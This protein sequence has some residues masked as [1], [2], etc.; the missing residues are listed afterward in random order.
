[1]FIVIVLLAVIG[2]LGFRYV[3]E[4]ALREADHIYQEAG[5]PASTRFLPD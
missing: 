4:E 5:Y 1:M 3:F 2:S